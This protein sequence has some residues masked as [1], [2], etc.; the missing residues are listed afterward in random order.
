MHGTMNINMHANELGLNHWDILV[1]I[2]PWLRTLERKGMLDNI[3]GREL[4]WN[5]MEFWYALLDDIAYRRGDLGDALAGPSV[6]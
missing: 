4:D 6:S 5:S 2:V 1:G 3:N